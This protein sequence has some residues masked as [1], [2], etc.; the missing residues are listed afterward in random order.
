MIYTLSS[1]PLHTHYDSKS[2]LVIYWKR[3]LIQKLSLQITMKSSCHFSFNHLGLPTPN[4]SNFY[5]VSCIPIPLILDSVLLCTTTLYYRLPLYIRGTN[6]TEKLP[7]AAR[8]V[9][10]VC[11]YSA[12]QQTVSTRTTQKTFLLL[13]GADHIENTLLRVLQRAYRAVA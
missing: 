4:F 5:P 1:S 11:Y 3:I 9:V 7:S 12:A 6:H 10:E 8:I 13:R 2:P